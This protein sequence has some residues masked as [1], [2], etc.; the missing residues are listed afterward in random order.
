MQGVSPQQILRL[1]TFKVFTSADFLIKE[2]NVVAG[3]NFDEIYC[4]NTGKDGNQIL[5][6][7]FV[8]FE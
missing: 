3:D 8:F 7:L 5:E 4:E 6:G 2:Q 1:Q